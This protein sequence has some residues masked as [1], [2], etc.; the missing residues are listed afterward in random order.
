M[1]EPF[2]FARFSAVILI[3]SNQSLTDSVASNIHTE[4]LGENV[5]CRLGGP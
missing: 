1:V 5:I 2:L 4:F 3:F